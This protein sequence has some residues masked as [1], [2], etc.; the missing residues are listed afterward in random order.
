M[1]LDAYDIQEIRR[2]LSVLT[3]AVLSAT[4]GPAKAEKLLQRWEAWMNEV[5]IGVCDPGPPDIMFDV[6]RLPD[7][8]P[9]ECE[10]FDGG[11]SAFPVT[12]HP[13]NLTA[14]VGPPCPKCDGTG[15]HHTGHQCRY[16]DGIGLLRE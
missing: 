12:P 4:G 7:G 2:A 15:W 1:K 14:P 16:C 3:E 8:P 9:E 5:R 6:S 13:R 11:A 10:S